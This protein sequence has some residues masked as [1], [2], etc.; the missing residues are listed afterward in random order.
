[1]RFCLLT[2]KIDRI[3]DD[4]YSLISEALIRRGHVA[5]CAAVDSL[6]LVHA[7]LY[8]TGFDWRGGLAPGDRPPATA[9]I[10]LEDNDVIWVLGLGER[11]TFLDKIQLLYTLRRVRII[12]S[13][14][15]LM[16]LKSK[17]LLT[18]MGD[19]MQHPET[20]ASTSPLELVEIMQGKGGRW[21]AKPPAGSL[22]RDV[23]LVD[24]DDKNALAIF[25]H[26][27]GPDEN[28][29]ALL[30]KYVPEIEKR[31]EKRVLVAAG[32]VVGHYRRLAKRDHRTNLAQA[33]SAES[34]TLTEEERDY[35][36]SI[37]EHLLS[38]GAAYFGIDLIFPWVIEVNV[39]NPGGLVTLRRL[40]GQD[41]S[42]LVAERV[43]SYLLG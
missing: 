38:M 17:Y 27:C 25:Q 29:Y 24:R 23:F 22:G 5:R 6:R 11:G 2:R 14:D 33:A 15:A 10:M 26:L 43:E 36:E 41:R 3:A 16:H 19:R 28:R 42:S 30:Q 40:D 1:M 18:G 34:T 13:L 8:A 31:G 7:G 32:K 39:V 9:P 4:N 21:V 12:N 37:G 35:C 20:Y